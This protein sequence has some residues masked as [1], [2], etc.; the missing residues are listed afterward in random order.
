MGVVAVAAS[1]CDLEE[2][3]E[4]AGPFSV[5]EQEGEE[6]A[7]ALFATLRALFMST[8]LLHSF[9][10]LSS[11]RLAE[12]AFVFSASLCSCSAFSHCSFFSSSLHSLDWTSR[13]LEA[14]LAIF[15]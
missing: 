5:L 13:A 10:I 9:L 11:N 8:S 15:T 1:F 4:S 12:L 14:S 6:T 3:E 7:K 2:E